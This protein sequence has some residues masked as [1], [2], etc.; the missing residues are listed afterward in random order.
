MYIWILREWKT[1]VSEVFWSLRN[2]IIPRP[3]YRQFFSWI[4][5]QRFP[6]ENHATLDKFDERPAASRGKSL[7]M[8]GREQT[9]A[10]FWGLK[11]EREANGEPLSL[12]DDCSCVNTYFFCFRSDPHQI[13][14]RREAPAAWRETTYSERFARVSTCET[15]R[16]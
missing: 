4:G 16:N 15:I 14:C 3:I 12:R 8:R 7:W 6:S 13:S 10:F 2:E 9:S 5:E 11:Q 1:I